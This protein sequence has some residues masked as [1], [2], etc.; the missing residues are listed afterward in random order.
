[1][2]S[3]Y[4]LVRQFDKEMEIFRMLEK[5]KVCFKRERKLQYI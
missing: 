3:R 1:M 5:L 4:I 2:T